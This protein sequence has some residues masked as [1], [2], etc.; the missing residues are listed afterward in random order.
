[1]SSV[2]LDFSCCLILVLRAISR[3]DTGVKQTLL[4]TRCDLQAALAWYRCCLVTVEAVGRHCTKW[5][6]SIISSWIFSHSLVLESY[7]ISHII[8]K[9]IIELNSS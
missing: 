6:L 2:H 4:S 3:E 7:Q 8:L 5:V 1:M 9:M